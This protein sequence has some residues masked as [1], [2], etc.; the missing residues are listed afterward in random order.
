MTNINLIDVDFQLFSDA[1][2]GDSGAT[3]QGEDLNAN[4]LVAVGNRAKGNLGEVKY[5]KIDESEVQ[6]DEVDQT[7]E[8]DAN[9]ETETEDFKSLIKGKFKDDFDKAVQN[10]LN[11]RF[12]DF[13]KLETSNNEVQPLLSLMASK[14]G[15]NP[16]ARDIMDAIQRDSAFYEA[17]AESMGMTTEGYKAYL[18]QTSEN[19]LLREYQQAQ[20]EQAEF[21]EKFDGWVEQG[22]RLKGLY[23]QFDLYEE[24]NSNDDFVKLLNSGVDVK[25]AFQACHS[26]E[27]LEGAMQYTAREVAKKTADSIANKRARPLEGSLSRQN[28][29]TIKSDVS[30]LTK[31]DRAEIARRVANGETIRF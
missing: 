9:A 12:R 8:Q 3:S 23:P 31:A 7:E 4:S 13:K 26:D 19:R 5:G 25:T 11:R 10:I 28:G 22:E 6:D 30:K 1:S 14:Y 21:Q 16:N 15:V 18:S 20:A 2:N 27:I 29:V 24:I 17:G